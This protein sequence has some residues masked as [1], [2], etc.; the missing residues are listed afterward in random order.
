M[1]SKEYL[2]HI[3]KICDNES[4]PYIHYE[5][6]RCSYY[7]FIKQDLEDYLIIREIEDNVRAGKKVI[8]NDN[9]YY[10]C[11]FILAEKGTIRHLTISN[12][13]FKIILRFEDYKKHWRFEE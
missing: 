2:E 10:A 11:E 9:K 7:G 8:F 6:S 12:R 4:C 3:C 13:K 1:K 5:N